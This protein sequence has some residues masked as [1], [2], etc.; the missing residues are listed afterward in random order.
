[1]KPT[2]LIIA[3]ILSSCTQNLYKGV[4]FEAEKPAKKAELTDINLTNLTVN[5]TIYFNDSLDI[6]RCIDKTKLLKIHFTDYRYDDISRGSMIDI[7]I[8]NGYPKIVRK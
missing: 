7:K 6:Y 8:E 1:M 4:A 5:G 3:V 2:I